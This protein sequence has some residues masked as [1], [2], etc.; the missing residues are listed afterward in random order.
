MPDPIR[1]RGPG[2]CVLAFE[3]VDGVYA[4]NR[5]QSLWLASAA[6]H[7]ALGWSADTRRPLGEMRALELCCGGGP[8]AISLK[9]GGVGHVEATDIS[10][11]AVERCRHNASLNRLELDLVA[12]RDWLDGE[13]DQS[14]PGF[15]LIVCNPPCRP[16]GDCPADLTPALRRSIDGGKEGIDY[17]LRL[18]DE[19]GALLRPQGRLLFNVV[20]T[21]NFLRVQEALRARFPRAWRLTSACPVASPFVELDS[22]RAEYLERLHRQRLIIAWDGGDGWIWRL[23]WAIVA[24]RTDADDPGKCDGRLW[25]RHHSYEIERPGFV[26]AVEHFESLD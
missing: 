20:S 23:T 25:Y 2:G 13:R 7:E 14:A 10:A 6:W 26:E 18:I 9:A 3:N 16:T 21:V 22:P 8:V 5:Y 24:T 17:M 1:H 15:D 12:R 11:A 19:G 4:V